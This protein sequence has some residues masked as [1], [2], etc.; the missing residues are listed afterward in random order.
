MKK[1]ILFAAAAAII[2]FASCQKEEAPVQN[3]DLVFTASIADNCTR[4]SID[5]GTG[6][7]AWEIG[8]EITITDNASVSVKYVVSKIDATSGKARF[9]KKSGEAGVIG[10]GPY[11]A[12]Y[13]TDPATAQAYSADVPALPMNAQSSTTELT[14]TVTCGLLEVELTAADGESTKDISKIEV[15]GT[16]TGGA[17]TV[18]ALDCSEAQS[19][20]SAKKFYMALPAGNYIAMKFT[21]SNGNMYY[22]TAKSAMTISANTIQ[23]KAISGIEFNDMLPGEFSVAEGK[24]VRFSKGNLRVKRTSSSTSDWTWGFYS[25]QYDINSLNT[26]ETRTA[27]TTDTEIDL[28]CW[29]YNATTSINP[30]DYS[31]HNYSNLTQSQ[32][33]GCTIGDGKTWRSLSKA[34]WEY[35]LKRIVP[36]TVDGSI[37]QYRYGVTVAGSPNCLVLYPDGCTKGKV[38]NNG[39]ITAAEWPV[40]EAMGAVCIPAAGG[41]EGANIPNPAQTTQYLKIGTSGSVWTSTLEGG[42]PRN[43]VFNAEGVGLSANSR[44]PGFSV[45]LITEVK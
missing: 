7:I 14:F 22:K 23:Q 15:I 42:Y 35:L 21:N 1:T 6:K 20:G 4:T 38:G 24:Q 27:A 39:T 10:D 34:E 18:Y 33:W 16:S 9:T 32:D 37:V 45:R 28:F 25:N 17:A 44:Y 30:V 26:G 2:T 31:Q 43:L 36:Y 29:G 40:A 3:C 5:A 8:D 41:R 11:T 19:I 13:G 12:V